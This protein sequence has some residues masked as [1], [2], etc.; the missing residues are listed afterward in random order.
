MS[1][2]RYAGDR[3]E[4]QHDNGDCIAP[5]TS[6]TPDAVQSHSPISYSGS[7]TVEHAL[8]EAHRVFGVRVIISLAEPALEGEVM[9][10]RLA[11]HGI[12]VELVPDDALLDKMKE[13][14]MVWLGADAYRDEEFVNKRGSLA[15]AEAAKREEKP[16]YVLVDHFKKITGPYA[17]DNPLF[18]LIPCGLITAIVT[19]KKVI[20]SL[21]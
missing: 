19:D 15:L 13:C 21:S 8:I 2:L 11:E 18:E 5:H 9:A 20:V 3:T 1:H 6:S 12:V 14:D 7:G 10:K 4:E 16:V 17:A